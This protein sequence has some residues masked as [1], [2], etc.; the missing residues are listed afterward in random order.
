MIHETL[1]FRFHGSITSNDN[2]YV[3]NLTKK[4]RAYTLLLSFF[5]F[6]Q[7]NVILRR[8]KASILSTQRG[9]IQDL[10]AVLLASAGML[11][12]VA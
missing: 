4:L 6:H 2:S 3:Y 12:N 7:R 8:S 5:S 11:P 9:F 10:R 1:K